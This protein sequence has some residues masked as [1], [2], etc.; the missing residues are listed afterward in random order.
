MIKNGGAEQKKAISFV[1]YQVIDIKQ[2]TKTIYIVIVE[3]G[4][5]IPI[6]GD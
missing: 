1:V 6:H 3:K 4:I 5:L 2:I